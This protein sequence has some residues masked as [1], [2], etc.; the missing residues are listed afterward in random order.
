MGTA[1]EPSGLTGESSSAQ[2][3]ARQ[4]DSC[5][6]I[7]AMIG[8]ATIVMMAEITQRVRTLTRDIR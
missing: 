7:V 2:N 1:D 6:P 3:A 5:M 8:E 4:Y